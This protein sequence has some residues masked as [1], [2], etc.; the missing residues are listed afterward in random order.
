MLKCHEIARKYNKYPRNLKIFS[1]NKESLKVTK[2]RTY[3]TIMNTHKITKHIFGV[4]SVRVIQ[5]WTSETILFGMKY[6]CSDLKYENFVNSISEKFS[7][8]RS[9]KCFLLKLLWWK[10]TCN[11]SEHKYGPSHGL[12]CTADQSKGSQDF[13]NWNHS[14]TGLGR[15]VSQVFVQVIVNAHL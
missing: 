8:F 5:S 1:K 3:L 11:F 12:T 6:V 15:G 10:D 4:F 14:E 9:C 13:Q 7:T 2:S